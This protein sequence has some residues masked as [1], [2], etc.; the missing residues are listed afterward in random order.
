MPRRPAALAVLSRPT[1]RTN[2]RTRIHQTTT[3]TN[4]NQPTQALKQ[5]KELKANSNKRIQVITNGKPARS[6]SRLLHRKD[7]Q[8]GLQTPAGLQLLS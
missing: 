8:Q 1:R 3:P 6:R 2:R 5:N 4:L 7:R